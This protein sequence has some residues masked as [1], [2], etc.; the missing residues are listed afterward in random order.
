MVMP[1]FHLSEKRMDVF[2]ID[3]VF[4]KGD[5]TIPIRFIYFASMYTTN[6]KHNNGWN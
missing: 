1:S 3:C 4:F 6:L 5:L 2:T